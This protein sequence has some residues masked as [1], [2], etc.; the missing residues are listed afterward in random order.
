MEQRRVGSELVGA[1]GLGAMPMSTR[2]E[3]DPVRAPRTIHAALDAGTTL[4]DTADAYSLTDTD[5]GHN[6]RLVGRA[7]R[8]WAGDPDDVLVA[9][10][11]GHVRT[12]AGGWRVDGRPEH[13]RAACD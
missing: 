11:G 2:P 7:V 5:V 9:T 13:L 3:R 1:V 6:E 8:S 4:V 10:K 12:S